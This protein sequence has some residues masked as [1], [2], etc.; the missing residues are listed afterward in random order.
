VPALIAALGDA[1]ESVRAYAAKALSRIGLSAVTGVRQNST[2]AAGTM[3][4]VAPDAEP[5]D[6]AVFCPREVAKHSVPLSTYS[7]TPPALRTK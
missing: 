6:A 2:E 1:N 5:V 4:P 3:N 7:S